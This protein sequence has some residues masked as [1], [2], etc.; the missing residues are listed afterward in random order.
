MRGNLP[1]QQLKYN[2]PFDGGVLGWWW[3]FWGD[4]GALG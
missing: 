3:G 1:T 2:F 4:G